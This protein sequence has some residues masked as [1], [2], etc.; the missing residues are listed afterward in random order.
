MIFL[1]PLGISGWRMNNILYL[2]SSLTS[3]Q[4]AQDST[5]PTFPVQ[6][7]NC[8]ARLGRGNFFLNIQISMGLSPVVSVVKNLPAKAGD[9]L[10]REFISW[11]RKIPGKGHGTPLQ[12]SSLENPM[13]RRAWQ[14]T[15]HAFAK[16]WTQLKWLSTYSDQHNL[17]NKRNFSS[18][19]MQRKAGSP[20]AIN[21]H[22]K[23]VFCWGISK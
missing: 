18:T 10:R 13:D 12:Y 16:S 11:V 4:T 3:Y 21:L 17:G 6:Q 1:A 7:S 15:V 20:T 22:Y 8:T 14:A 2:W 23:I 5:P 19:S 9:I